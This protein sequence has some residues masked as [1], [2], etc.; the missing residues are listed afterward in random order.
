MELVSKYIQN[1]LG[2][3][4]CGLWRQATTDGGGGVGDVFGAE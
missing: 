2:C 3:G 4:V 1:T